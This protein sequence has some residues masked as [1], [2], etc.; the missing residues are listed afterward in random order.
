MKP[1]NIG[2]IGAGQNARGHIGCIERS[3][4]LDILAVA[5]PHGPSIE[6]TKERLSGDVAVFED[7]AQLL[8]NSDVEAVI[9]SVPNCLHAEIACAALAAGK[10]VLSEKPMATSVEDCDRMIAARDASGKVL[11]IGL[12]LRCD[13]AMQKIK[14]L[15]SSGVIGRP[16]SLWIKEFRGPFL[17]K[18]DR[19]ITTKAL[20]GDTLLE[21][22]CN[23]YDL[24]NW[25]ADSPVTRAAGFGGQDVELGFGDVLDNAWTIQEHAN[26][27]RSALGLCMFCDRGGPG[28]E[29]GVIGAEGIVQ[30]TYGEEVKLHLRK[31]AEMRVYDVTPPEDIV[32]LSHGGAMY[33]EHEAWVRSIREGE[34]VVVT[35]EI[36]R[37]SVL[38][39]L[40]CTRAVAERRVVDVDKE[41]RNKGLG[42]ET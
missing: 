10:H 36:G 30:Y 2:L 26:K 22:D 25:F 7:Y 1:L 37:E 40:A 39:A 42:E 35:G 15:V 20:S 13:P 5:D 11:Q 23:H 12:E 18:V 3:D 27:A 41:F 9:I 8:S 17:V 24:F 34:P 33:Y 21:K 31:R 6:E 4:S 38:V 32:S 28:I 29:V 19:W 14:E 16:Y